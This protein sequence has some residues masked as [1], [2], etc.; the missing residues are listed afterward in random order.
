M[1]SRFLPLVLLFSCGLPLAQPDAGVDA[2]LP[3]FSTEFLAAPEALTFAC[4]GATLDDGTVFVVGTTNGGLDGPSAKGQRDAFLARYAPDGTRAWVR[5]LGG[6]A[7]FPGFFVSSC[8]VRADAEGNTIVAGTTNGLGTLEGKQV[9]NVYGAFV[10]RLDAQ[11]QVAWLE[12][13][14]D[15][16]GPTETMS[17]ELLPDGRIVVVGYTRTSTLGGAAS[18]GAGDVFLAFYSPLGALESVRRI[19]G[20]GEDVPSAFELA[21]DSL[22][23]A[24]RVL[25]GAAGRV[26]SQSLRVLDLSGVELRARAL[27]EPFVAMSL[28]ATDAG[29]GLVSQEIASDGGVGGY[30]VELRDS[31]LEPR[32]ST[33]PEPRGRR[34]VFGFSCAG[35]ACVVSGSTTITADGGTGTLLEGFVDSFAAGSAT[36][37]QRWADEV[38]IAATRIT[39]VQHVRGE[40][41]IVGFSGGTL[42]SRTPV[43]FADSFVE[44]R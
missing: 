23:L 5:Q 33:T 39:W 44:R 31:S 17:L 27:T 20:A 34:S 2:G 19:G 8:S 14:G 22:V 13:L 18:L 29:I 40:L 16:S 32:W 30:R 4:G 28:S 10:A 9:S 43:G 21:G 38:G 25:D 41:A 11:G 24:T 3:V 12:L 6:P 42:Q 35:E 1:S 15:A 37:T 7:P 36:G 26:V